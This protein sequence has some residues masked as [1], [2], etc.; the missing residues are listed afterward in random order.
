MFVHQSFLVFIIFAFRI[1]V[2]VTTR[3]YFICQMLYVI[4]SLFGILLFSS[5]KV[6]LKNLESDVSPGIGP[7]LDVSF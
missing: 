1:A 6:N 4:H 2:T 7:N 5:I 3:V